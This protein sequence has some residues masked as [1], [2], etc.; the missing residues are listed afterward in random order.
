MGKFSYGTR[1]A[2][3]GVSHTWIN[4]RL[5]YLTTRFVLY[6]LNLVDLMAIDWIFTHDFPCRSATL[7]VEWCNDCFDNR[8]VT[9]NRS[10]LCPFTLHHPRLVIDVECPSLGSHSIFL[11]NGTH[12]PSL[13]FSPGSRPLNCSS[14][15]TR[16]IQINTTIAPYT[17]T[18]FVLIKNSRNSRTLHSSIPS[19]SRINE[20][21]F[22]W[23]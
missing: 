16:L 11:H 13:D 14:Y 9:L 4:V 18:L 12:N 22:S 17:C 3:V 5:T 19:S 10:V 20:M 1:Q 15:Y 7:F 8:N 6:G 2:L 23:K 21:S